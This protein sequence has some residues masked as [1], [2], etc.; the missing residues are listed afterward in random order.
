M[1]DFRKLKSRR[2]LYFLVYARNA[3]DMVRLRK[4]SNK[5]DKDKTNLIFIRFM[6]RKGL[7][8]F[9]VFCNSSF[10]SVA[11]TQGSL[12][13]GLIGILFPTRSRCAFNTFQPS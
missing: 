5:Q 9:P 8:S 11:K 10:C 2:P 7:R 3:P 13:A 6:F 4:Q 12:N 1:I